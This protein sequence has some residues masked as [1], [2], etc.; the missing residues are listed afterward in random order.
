MEV[1]SEMSVGS[2]FT[3]WLPLYQDGT[4]LMLLEEAEKTMENSDNEVP[5]KMW[6]AG[7]REIPSESA[8]P[9]ANNYSQS[10]RTDSLERN[11]VKES[12]LASSSIPIAPQDTTSPVDTAIGSSL[13]SNNYLLSARARSSSGSGGEH[14]HTITSKAS[15]TANPLRFRTPPSAQPSRSS[16]GFQSNKQFHREVHDVC[17]VLSVDDDPINQMVV[18]NLLIPDGYKV[19]Q[20]M[21]GNEAL[22]FLRQSE[23]LPDVILLD[24]MMPDMSGYEVCH[25]IRRQYSSVSIPIIM[26]SAMG[27]PE[28]VTRG[29]EAGSVDYV[30]KPF[31]RQELLSR[32]RAQVRNREVFEAE[33]ESRKVTDRLKKIMP[34]SVVQRLQAGQSMI[35]DAHQEVT[36]LFADV[37]EFW[38]RSNTTTEVVL[39]MN[40]MYKMFESLLDKHQVF[41]VEHS[42]DS[43]M[44]ISG[45]DGSKDHVTRILGLA[46]DMLEASNGVRYASGRSLRFRIGMHTGPAYAGVVGIESPRYCVFGDTVAIASSLE[47][48]AHP[49]TIQVSDKVVELLPENKELFAPYRN[50]L[51]VTTYSMSTHIVKCGDYEDALEA[52]D[53]VVGSSDESAGVGHLEAAALSSQL[54]ATRDEQRRLKTELE[55]AALERELMEKQAQVKTYLVQ[56]LKQAVEVAEEEKEK[57][58]ERHRQLQEESAAATAAALAT[59]SSSNTASPSRLQQRYVDARH[60]GTGRATADSLDTPGSLGGSVRPESV[61]YGSD[62]M[63]LSNKSY[64]ATHMVNNFWSESY[65][66]DRFLQD[67]G[68]GQYHS[69][70]A[71][72]EVTP[73]VLADASDA[74]LIALGVEKFG[75]RRRIQEAA[76]QYREKMATMMRLMM[77][78]KESDAS[79]HH[80]MGMGEGAAE[81]GQGEEAEEEALPTGPVSQMLAH[82]K[83]EGALSGGVDTPTV[84]SPHKST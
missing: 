20:A 23:V 28:H 9:K 15:T 27:N 75:A 60:F 49:H 8:Q 56:S 35:A 66:L 57:L 55:E 29:L 36:V 78:Y 30:K 79:I 47:T 2:T 40:E 43:Y 63:P 5:Y 69:V 22:D 10:F 3:V 4:P 33:M 73:M 58:E 45:H 12:G 16:I 82:H 84:S 11:R 77:M 1:V 6:S 59:A 54:A 74:D 14:T 38:S 17:L 39:H 18:E 65:N 32:V 19:E 72:Q 68:L 62:I 51:L 71:R 21:S 50:R 7:R 25:E 53:T 41:R 44:A 80:E 52:L 42:G 13:Y 76:G 81:E 61:V 46:Q 34:M 24:I 31:H 83:R 26:V 67:I 70:L 37:A 48:S 64:V